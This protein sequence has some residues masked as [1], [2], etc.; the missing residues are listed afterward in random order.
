[1]GKGERMVTRLEEAKNEYTM[2]IK[3]YRKRI[4]SLQ[5]Q[6]RELAELFVAKEDIIIVRN[7]HGNPHNNTVAMN[8]ATALK[9][10]GDFDGDHNVLLPLS[11]LKQRM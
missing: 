11:R 8:T 9:G 6:M 3:S 7:V 10:R 4:S 5:K 1:M 2:K